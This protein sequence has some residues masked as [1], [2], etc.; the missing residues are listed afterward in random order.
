M[1]AAAYALLGLFA[2]ISAASGLLA[3][4]LVRPWRWWAPAPPILGSFGALYLVGHR[5]G[6]SVGPEVPLFGFRVSLPFDVAVALAVALAT[7]ATQAGALRLLQPQQRS[8]GRD[9][10]A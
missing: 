7:A 4:R 10:N 5:L 8:P 2:A 6:W 9:S 3:S 1:P